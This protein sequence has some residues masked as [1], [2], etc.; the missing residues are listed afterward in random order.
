MKITIAPCDHDLQLRENTSAHSKM[1]KYHCLPINQLISKAVSC[2]SHSKRNDRRCPGCSRSLHCK[3]GTWKTP[4]ICNGSET[5]VAQADAY[6]V[7]RNTCHRD[8]AAA[9]LKIRMTFG[10]Q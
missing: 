8:L 4:G 2:E 6:L 3:N 10:E 7:G 5:G 1:K 9:A